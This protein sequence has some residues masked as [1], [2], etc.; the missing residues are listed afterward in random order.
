MAT[1]E[2]SI[3]EDVAVSPVPRTRRLGPLVWAA[4]A[5]MAFVFAAAALAGL[6][7]LASPTHRDVLERWALASVLHWLGSHGFGQHILAHLLYGVRISLTVGL[8]APV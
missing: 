2:L 6:L 8:C 7:S 4:I 1:L 5:W 3:D